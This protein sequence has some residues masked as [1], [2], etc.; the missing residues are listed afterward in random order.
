MKLEE[1]PL[2]AS[3]EL[4]YIKHC[5]LMKNSCTTLQKIRVY[6]VRITNTINLVETVS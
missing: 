5:C 1:I 2:H 6:G 3:Y 4:N